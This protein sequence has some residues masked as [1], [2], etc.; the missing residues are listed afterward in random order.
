MHLER[1]ILQPS[2]NEITKD[3][4]VSVS[5]IVGILQQQ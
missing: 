4:I 2:F 5:E 1:S 3:S